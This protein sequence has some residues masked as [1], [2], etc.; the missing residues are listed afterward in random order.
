METPGVLGARGLRIH[1]T[2]HSPV[3][4]AF[5]RPLVGHGVGRCVGAGLGAP[6]YQG[7]LTGRL[8]QAHASTLQTKRCSQWEPLC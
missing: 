5:P 8:P 3:S 7:E 4:P 6:H 1:F 2:H